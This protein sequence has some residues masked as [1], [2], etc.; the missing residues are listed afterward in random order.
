MNVPTKT[1]QHQIQELR[2]LVDDARE[3]LDQVVRGLDSLERRLAGEASSGSA[4]RP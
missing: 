2:K 1:P 3:T 4:P